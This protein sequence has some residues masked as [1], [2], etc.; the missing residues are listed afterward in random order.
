M[1]Y[2]PPSPDPFNQQP[3]PY[4]PPPTPN[5]YAPQPVSGDPY[6]AP[7]VSADPYAAPAVSGAPYS[8]QPT[9]A[10][11]VPFTP[12][13]QGPAAPGTNGMAIA[14]MVLG[15]VGVLLCCCY[16]IGALPGL[17]GAVLGHISLKQVKQTGQQ[18]RGMAIAGIATGWSAVALTAIMVVLLIIG[19]LNDPNFWNEIQS[20]SSSSD[21]D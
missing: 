21:W 15:I 20:G 3:D 8:P 7:P 9:G 6:A 19:V 5:P 17:I 1:T 13:A 4:A 16:G 2:P 10:Y 14:S 18:G 11:G 12:Y